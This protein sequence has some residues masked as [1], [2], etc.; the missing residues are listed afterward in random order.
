M[1]YLIIDPQSYIREDLYKTYRTITAAK[2]SLRA[3][4]KK[5]KKA[6]DNFV[7]KHGA[8]G[9]WFNQT[10]VR[11]EVVNRSIVITEDEFEKKEP[12]VIRKCLRTGN[13]YAERLN[14]PPCLSRASE[15]HWDS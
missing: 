5:A 9:D 15:T 1:T 7:A 3:K 6:Y 8:D 4:Q 10:D 2:I 14:T 12:T 11:V 13:T